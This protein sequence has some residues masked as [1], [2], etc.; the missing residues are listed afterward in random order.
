[1]TRIEKAFWSPWFL[2]ALS[3]VEAV[4]Q[5]MDD[6]VGYCKSPAD[7]LQCHTFL[8]SC[9]QHCLCQQHSFVVEW[10]CLKP[11]WN[12]TLTPSLPCILQLYAGEQMTK[13]GCALCCDY[14]SGNYCQILTKLHMMVKKRIHCVL[15]P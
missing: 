14:F 6:G 9:A 15:G 12:V 3:V 11:I 10:P 7:F 2:D 5:F 8:R 4:S 1:M 13:C